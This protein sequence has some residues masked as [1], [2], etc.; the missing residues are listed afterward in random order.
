VSQPLPDAEAL[1]ALSARYAWARAGEGG[2]AVALEEGHTFSLNAT[3]VHILQRLASCPRER[4]L[5]QVAADFGLSTAAASEAIAAVLAAL[6]SPGEAPA[7]PT[8]DFPY[9]RVGDEYLLYHRE[10]PVL[11]VSGDSTT[12]RL[13]EARGAGLPLA[14]LLR[15][16]SPKILQA[17]GVVVLHAAASGGNEGLVVFSGR[18]GA[19]KSTTSRLL[20]EARGTTPFADDLLVLSGEEG[21]PRA[22]AGA[23]QAI[24]RWCDKAGRRLLSRPDEPVDLAGLCAAASD[25]AAALAPLDCLIFVA[26]DR[27]RGTTL[28]LQPLTAHEAML[29]LLS[30]VFLGTTAPAA[31]RQFLSACATLASAVPM[32]RAV[33]PEGLPALRAA[34]PRDLVPYISKI[35]SKR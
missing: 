13:T 16:A 31:V 26:A 10:T 12:A 21:P 5:A 29:E 22:R 14:H 17:R 3:A 23:E 32:A 1:A 30:A 11:R 2:V 8:D 24:Y 7:A 34:L 27:R 35:T 15:L 20:A 4:L 28:A 6:A 33:V 18:S 19:G 9:K 25:P